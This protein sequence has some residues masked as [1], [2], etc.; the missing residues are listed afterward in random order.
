MDPDLRDLLAAWHGGE[1]DPARQE[2][3]LERVRVD[4]PFRQ[5][6]VAEVWMLGMLKAVQSAEPRWLR[7]EDEIGWGVE[8]S[9]ADSL[10]DRIVGRLGEAAVNRPRRRWWRWAIAALIPLA[11]IL[12]AALFRPRGDGGAR[13]PVAKAYPRVDA[14]AGLA[15]VVKL[16]GVRWESGDD[17]HPAEGDV[18]AAGSL[19]FRS[20]RLTLS[21]LTG[22]SLTVEGPADVELVSD[23]KVVCRRGRMRVRSSVGEQGFL[24]CGPDSAV[25]DLGTEF[26]VNVGDDGTA[27]ARVF[28]G[29][30]ESAIMG[31]DGTFQR[32]RSF[33]ENE[34]FEIDPPAGEI[35]PVAGAVDFLGP[36]NLAIPPLALSRDY[37][38]A[39]RRSRPWGYWRFETID[40]GVAVNEVA[41][42]PAMRVVG[43]IRLAANLGG[44]RC[45]ELPEGRDRQ[46]LE[47]E[48][49]WQPPWDSG[50]AVELWAIS[51]RIS[52]STLVSISSPQD[53]NNHVMLLELTSRN[54][55]HRPASVRFLH[56]W[57][58]GGSGGDNLYSHVPYVPYR[59]H[60]VVAQYRG[61]RIELFVDGEAMPPLSVAPGHGGEPCKLLV[62]RLTTRPGT[63]IS[64]D[65]PLIGRIDEMALYDHPLTI[66]EV[67]EHQRLGARTSPSP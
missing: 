32:T 33:G 53:E 35:G 14:S 65:R 26:G 15:M 44:N 49:L 62:G 22:V 29:R 21:M 43:P 9:T 7:L 4:E 56:R 61:D 3:L 63:G 19:R 16:D 13:P 55:L 6:F 58:P 34:A 23:N 11:A 46:D 54:L 27:R 37:S 18:L 25:L 5:A 38:A 51:E 28:D 52:H 8:P 59:W 20:G 42:R 12:T 41:G 64:I 39:V 40:G 60:H 17:P 50:F 45:L 24:V 67:R 1:I 10:E 36:T 2:Q 47:L 57:P 66:D 30:V 48:G 31:G